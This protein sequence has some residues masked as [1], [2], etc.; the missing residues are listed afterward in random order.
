MLR[1][2]GA[3]LLLSTAPLALVAQVA[4][5][6]VV[7]DLLERI[8]ADLNDLRYAEAITSGRILIA[9]AG[10]LP[11]G[12]R[13]RAH[14]LL[15]AAFFP[16]DTTLQ[17]S[18]SA[19]AHLSIAIRLTPDASYP[20]DLRWRG[21]DSLVAATRVATVAA[22]VRV[23]T[24]QSIGGP[25][26]E[27]TVELVAS[28]FSNVTMRLRSFED[29]G[30]VREDSASGETVRFA[31]PLHDGTAILLRPGRFDLALVARRPGRPDSIV[32]HRDLVLEATP[33]LLV[34]EPPLDPSLLLPVVGTPDRRGALKL[35]AGTA[36][37]TL[38]F[39]FVMRSDADLR[40]S[41]G[42]D[43]RAY[44]V[45]GTIAVTVTAF[46]WRAR[47]QPIPANV[48]KNAAT[49]ALHDRSV[50]DLRALNAERLTPYEGTL[51]VAGGA[52]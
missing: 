33:P 3:S 52:P 18:D 23:P 22:V 46:S 7:D 13:T 45:A 5:R 36:L 34:T 51:I 42:V 40:A 11:I 16:E 2:L 8:T 30:L 39:A 32:L 21:L 1:I 20:A 25:G 37:A 24:R 26:R 27:A 28:G 12:T 38:A 50:R 19:V 17:Q 48:V 35:G 9:Q 43:P 31:I 6:T 14:L 10:T 4:P 29:G 41:Y 15:A 47:A 44:A 49:R